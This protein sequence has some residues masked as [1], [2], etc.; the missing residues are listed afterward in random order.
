[1]ADTD[2]TKRQQEIDWEKRFFA[3]VREGIAAADKGDFA[4]EEEVRAVAEKY[5]PKH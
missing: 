3:K 4:S 5:R 1:M 2:G